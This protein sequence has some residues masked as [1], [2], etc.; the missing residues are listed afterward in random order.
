[1]VR[2][3][4]EAL[5]RRSG[6]PVVCG[7]VLARGF[8]LRTWDRFLIPFPFAR[9]RVRYAVADSDVAGALARLTADS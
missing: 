9:V 5:A 8:R 1:E 4:A 2:P 7:V 3:G 6:V